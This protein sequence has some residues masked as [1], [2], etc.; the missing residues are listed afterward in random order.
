MRGGGQNARVS[1]TFDASPKS[2]LRM[3]KRQCWKSCWLELMTDV[4][5]EKSFISNRINNVHVEKRH[6]NAPKHQRSRQRLKQ[7]EVRALPGC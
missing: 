2:Q 7:P 3:E 1:D 5:M 4:M 6:S